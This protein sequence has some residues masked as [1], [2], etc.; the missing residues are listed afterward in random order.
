MYTQ[1]PHT[2]TIIKYMAYMYKGV[3]PLR[4]CHH[5]SLIHITIIYDITLTMYVCM[6]TQ[7][8]H[9]HTYIKYM[10][11]MYKGVLPLRNCHHTSLNY[12]I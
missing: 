7:A 11:Y 6:Y 4:I 1:T 5:T 9:T 8:P 2:Q 12:C 10:V 3:L